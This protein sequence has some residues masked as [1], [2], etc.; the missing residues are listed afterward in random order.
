MANKKIIGGV[1]I[2]VVVV[3]AVVV[4]MVML[5]QGT[6]TTPVIGNPIAPGYPRAG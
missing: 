4:V 1:V 5:P 2:A 3:A 6:D